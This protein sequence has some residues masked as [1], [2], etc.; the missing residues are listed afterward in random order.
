MNRRTFF[1]RLVGAASA[2]VVA[3]AIVKASDVGISIRFIRA[4]DIEVDR[5]PSRFTAFTDDLRWY[6]EQYALNS[7]RERQAQGLPL[8][9][10]RPR[11]DDQ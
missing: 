6:D 4:Y 8:L 3:P 5:H 2:A 9:D 11:G 7:L 10:V 1:S